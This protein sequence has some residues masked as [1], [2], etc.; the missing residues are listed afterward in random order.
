MR[1]PQRYAVR[2]GIGLLVGVF[3]CGGGGGDTGSLSTGGAVNSTSGPFATRG[4]GDALTLTVPTAS[5]LIQGMYGTSFDRIELSLS[6]GESATGLSN[7]AGSVITYD[8]GG[9]PKIYDV[10]LGDTASPAVPGPYDETPSYVSMSPSHDRLVYSPR[11]GGVD[12]VIGFNANGSGLAGLTNDG[13]SERLP[14]FSPDGQKVAYITTNAPNQ[15]RVVSPAGGA[16]KLVI[17]EPSGIGTFAWSTDSGSI[18]Y[19][20]GS[21]QRD[22]KL[23]NLATNQAV[24]LTT[25]ANQIRSITP[26]SPTTWTFS[27]G[28]Q[29]LIQSQGNWFFKP[30]PNFIQTISY[31]PDYQKMVVQEGNTGKIVIRKANDFAGP[32]LTTL[33]NAGNNPAW[34]PA[35]TR[36]KFIPGNHGTSA[37]GFLYGLKGKV[38]T[39]ILTVDS[40]VPSTVTFEGSETTVVGAGT[41][42]VTIKA[43]STLTALSFQNR[44]YGAPKQVINVSSAAKGVV[45][46]YD[47]S[48]GAVAYILPFNAKSPSRSVSG[49]YEGDFSAV[50][51]RNGKNLSPGG[52]KQVRVSPDGKTASVR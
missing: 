45:V 1:I 12:K 25:S 30:L 31:S 22:L 50:F 46:V 19:S 32:I 41:A 14:I 15:L 35:A 18:A 26:A 39:S 24:K 36:R 38:V 13:N 3:G 42:A 6:G 28:S 20:T 40:P 11:T 10:T 16:S 2:V 49:T 33:E 48:D 52:A 17:S 9:Y 29:L 4:I 7:N 34:T 27:T 47:G 21:T 43:P 8:V 44:T 5:A 23:V 37:S 51:D